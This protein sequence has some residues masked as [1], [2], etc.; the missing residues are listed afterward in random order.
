MFGRVF[1]VCRSFRPSVRP[2][3]VR[4]SVQIG[5]CHCLSK[6][7][8]HSIGQTATVGSD[9]AE[10]LGNLKYRGCT[11]KVMRNNQGY[12]DVQRCVHFFDGSTHSDI[13][14]Y[15]FLRFF[16]ASHS[17]YSQ[18]TTIKEYTNSIMIMIFCSHQSL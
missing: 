11:I 5:I 6:S 1:L 2:A 17:L 4:R 9:L 13:K 10:R 16:P 12:R 7:C 3:S 15:V 14:Q 8:I 18:R